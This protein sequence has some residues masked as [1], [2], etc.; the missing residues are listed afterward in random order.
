MILSVVY[1]HLDLQ[2]HA[3]QVINDSL[4]ILFKM[5]DFLLDLCLIFFHSFQIDLNLFLDSV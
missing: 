5:I 1:Q 3:A 2:I 4:L